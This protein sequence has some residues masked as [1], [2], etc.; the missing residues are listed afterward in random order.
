[1]G[2]GFRY[3]LKQIVTVGAAVAFGMAGMALALNAQSHAV[4]E[5]AGVRSPAN[6]P[7]PSAPVTKANYVIGPGDVLSINV[8]NEQEVTGKVPVRPDG[9]ITV[10]LIGDVEASGLTPDKLQASITKKLTDYVKDPSVTVVVE[11]MNSRQFNVLGKVQH[12]GAFPLNKPTRVLDALALAGG[13][14]EFAKKNK[15][16]VL[17]TNASGTVARL[18]FDY[19]KVAAGEDDGENVQLQTGDTVIVP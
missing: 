17:R 6:I 10:P 2:G 8:M 3:A 9:M 11:E 1:M 14:N 7:S 15:V 19:K 12:P 4:T 13:F 5:E 18:P 16:Y